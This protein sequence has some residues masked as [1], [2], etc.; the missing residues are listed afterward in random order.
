MDRPSG[1]RRTGERRRLW[2][3]RTPSARRA[4]DD[5]RHRERRS[6]EQQRAAERR[7]AKDR[8][9]ADR[10]ELERRLESLRRRGRRRRETPTPY[11]IEEA[12]QLKARFAAPGP[13]ECPACG[14]GFTLGPARRRGA[15][16]ARRVVCRGCGRAAVVPNSRPARI[17]LIDPHNTVRDSLQAILAAAGHEV[18]EAAD[19]GVAL[20]A[21]QAVPADVVFI[22]VHA[23]GRMEMPEFMRRL[24][25]AFPEA[26]VVAIAGRPSYTGGQDPLAVAQGLGAVRTIRMPISREQLLQI[27]E[28]VR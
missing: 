6:A 15:E 16:I 2:D 23:T 18:I 11:S 7:A 28:E 12:T 4:A 27:V 26:R 19:A 10:R 5:R 17:L 22:N 25:R 14:S 9:K 8:R 21:Y 13:V 1:Q 24:R 3:R 20:A